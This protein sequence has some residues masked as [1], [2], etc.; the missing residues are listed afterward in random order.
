MYQLG[1]VFDNH[2]GHCWVIISVCPITNDYLLVNWTTW[3]SKKEQTCILYKGEHCALD[4]KSII[5]YQGGQVFT[6]TKLDRL[7]L[8]N[9][10]SKLPPVSNNI[11]KKIREGALKT[12]HMDPR[13]QSRFKDY[14]V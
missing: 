12:K 13:V 11:L 14:L 7:V 9:D 10:F 4:H 6:D 2:L 8:A 1:D 5:Y 3:T